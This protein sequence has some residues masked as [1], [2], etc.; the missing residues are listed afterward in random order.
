MRKIWKPCGKVS[1]GSQV[2]M[3]EKC[4]CE[5]AQSSLFLSFATMEQDVE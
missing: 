4:K 2:R 3:R 5:G 1:E